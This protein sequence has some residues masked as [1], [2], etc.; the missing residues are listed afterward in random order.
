MQDPIQASGEGPAAPDLERPTPAGNPE[1]HIPDDFGLGLVGRAL[2]WIAIAFATF[3]IVR[4]WRRKCL[5][6]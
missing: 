6:Y 5:N 4:E 3:Q 2:F 1:L